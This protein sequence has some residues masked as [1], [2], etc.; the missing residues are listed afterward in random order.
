MAHWLADRRNFNWP[1]LLSITR[2]LLIPI[3]LLLF[4]YGNEQ[5]INFLAIPLLVFAMFSD[6]LDGYLAR[7]FN[8]STELGRILDPVADKLAVFALA[9]YLYYAMAFPLWLLIAIICKDVLILVG[10]SIMFSRGK[11]VTPAA[12]LGK[13]TTAVLFLL[14]LVYI[15]GY[16][17]EATALEYISALLIVA[18]ILDYSRV[19]LLGLR[20]GN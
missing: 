17:E 4:V 14:F 7:N 6:W 18:S 9:L 15:L 13:A 12:L 16:G 19:F 5:V 1:N 3:I 20:G 11:G 10:A 8:Q 2:I